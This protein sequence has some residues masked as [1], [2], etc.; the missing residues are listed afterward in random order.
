MT[1]S[2]EDENGVYH[3]LVNEEGQHSIWPSFIE[4]PRGVD[5]RSRIRQPHHLPRIHKPELDRHAPEKLDRKHEEIVRKR[6]TRTTISQHSF[7]D[8]AEEQQEF[9]ISS[10]A[11]PSTHLRTSFRCLPGRTARC[12]SRSDR[13]RFHPRLEMS[14]RKRA[15]PWRPGLRRSS[16]WTYQ[17][18]QRLCWF[19]ACI[20]PCE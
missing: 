13:S 8:R 19:P 3:V 11:P 2:F 1:N 7:R 12:M 14:P 9:G 6:T 15:S 5:H 10:G 17:D 4:V 16:S 18:R 20:I